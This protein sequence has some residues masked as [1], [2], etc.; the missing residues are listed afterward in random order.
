[1][2]DIG[3]WSRVP[4]TDAERENKWI[5]VKLCVILHGSKTTSPLKVLKIITILLLLTICIFIMFQIH[6]LK[7]AQSIQHNPGQWINVHLIF[8][9]NSLGII[10][11]KLPVRG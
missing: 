10:E 9:L 6:P 3:V 8:I 2:T 7:H 1:M 5:Y 11:P 4:I